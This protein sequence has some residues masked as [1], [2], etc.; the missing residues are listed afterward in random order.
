MMEDWII[1][2][3]IEKTG[4]DREKINQLIHKKREEFP[5][6]S[7]DAALRMVA[8]DNGVVPIRRN[9]KIRDI[10]EN[11]SHININGRI[12]KTTRTQSSRN[13]GKACTSNELN[14]RR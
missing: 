1:E 2:A 9:Y 6:L 8:T 12:K 4:I 13:Q 7:E 3:I 11:I 10:T 5:D 14:F